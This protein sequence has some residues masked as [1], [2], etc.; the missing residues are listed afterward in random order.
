[1]HK[2]DSGVG[3]GAVAFVGEMKNQSRVC[4]KEVFMERN[5]DVLIVGGGVAGMSAGIYA[6]RSGKNVAIIEKM[7]LGGTVGTLNQIEN[8]PSQASVDGFT[9]AQMFV[10]QVKKLEIE[11]ISDDILSV[12]FGGDL[13]VLKGKK[14]DYR[15]K[16]V[17]IATGI[18][19][20]ELGKN[21]EEFLGRGVSYCATCDANFFKGQTVCVVSRKGSGIAEAKYLSNI[22]KNVIVLDEGDMTVFAKANK[23]QNIEVV[24]NV[25]VQKI[26]GKDAVEGVL[27][28]QNGKEKKFVASGVFVALGRKPKTDIYR[29]KLDLDAQGFIKTNENMETSVSGVYAVGDVRAGVMKQIVTACSDGA[30]AGKKACEGV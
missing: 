25:S 1:M 8:F 18:S 19:Y 24:S 27:C 15:A 9:L 7:A 12:E 20:I 2:Q 16:K 14:G 4:E 30:I 10:E 21:E 28:N 6:K 13:K 5:F 26:F 3:L 17:I 11:I 29:G 23:V 22:V